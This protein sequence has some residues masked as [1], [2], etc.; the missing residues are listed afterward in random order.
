MPF[1]SYSYS[2]SNDCWRRST[3]C[4]PLFNPYN[5]WARFN[6]LCFRG[7]RGLDQQFMRTSKSIPW[8]HDTWMVY[9]SCEKKNC[10]LHWKRRFGVCCC[11]SSP[12][13]PVGHSEGQRHD[14]CGAMRRPGMRI[15]S[16]WFQELSEA[17]KDMSMRLKLFLRMGVG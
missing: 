5:S 7:L 16:T 11:L 9:L 3:F 14:N 6:N 1:I 10:H 12:Y 4:C 17:L 2:T 13:P 8:N 15:W